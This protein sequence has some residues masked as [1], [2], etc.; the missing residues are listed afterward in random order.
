LRSFCDS[1]VDDFAFFSSYSPP[2]SLNG[3]VC[4][5]R[6]CRKCT[7][8]EKVLGFP[9]RYYYYYNNQE[10]IFDSE[11]IQLIIELRFRIQNTVYSQVSYK[12]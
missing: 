3:M 2:L 8:R 6:E 1:F 4:Q 7:A 9:R 11:N 10:E 5:T 12:R